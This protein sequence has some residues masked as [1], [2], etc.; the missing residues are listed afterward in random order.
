MEAD[1]NTIV[2]ACVQCHQ[3]ANYISRSYVPLS[4][5]IS[6]ISFAQW[7]LD[8]IKALLVAPRQFKYVIVAVDYHTKWIE[9]EP[10]AKIT[11][12]RVVNFLW[13]CVYCWFGVPEAFVMDNGT[14]FDNDKFCAFA[15]K[16]GTNFLYASPAHPQ[17][18]GE[19][20]VINKLI[21]HNLKRASTR[22][23]DFELRNS[24]V[25]WALQTTPM[26]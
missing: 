2:G 3:Y 24:E 23:P 13:C 11:M 14:Q 8:L 5:I 19:V 26:G 10:L 25:L 18:N 15:H 1:A 7:G 4:V 22:P 20:E 16:N 21:K 17:T 12:G 9:A 6:P